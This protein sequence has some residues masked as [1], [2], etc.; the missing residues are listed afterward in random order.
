[1]AYGRD[2]TIF[3]GDKLDPKAEES[4]LARIESLSEYYSKEE[5]DEIGNFFKA[6]GV[7]LTREGDTIQGSAHIVNYFR[8]LR[9]LGVPGVGF[10][11]ECV[12]V[13]A[14]SGEIEENIRIRIKSDN[15]VTHVAYMVINYSFEFE[16]VEV[17]PPSFGEGFHIDGCPWW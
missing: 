8:H 11:A 12:F 4:L 15:R 3:L 9:S 16:G 13:K 6:S 5:F 1:M 10:N 17:D 14:V 7:L 2:K